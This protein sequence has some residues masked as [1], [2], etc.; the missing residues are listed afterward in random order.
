MQREGS[1]PHILNLD[2]RSMKRQ[3]LPS[4]RPMVPTGDTGY[5][6]GIPKLEK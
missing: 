3:L 5:D 6:A 1:A 4:E 2:I